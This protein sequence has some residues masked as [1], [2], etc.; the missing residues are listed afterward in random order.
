[1]YKNIY[2]DRKTGTVHLWDSK[3]GYITF[4]YQKYAYVQHPNGEYKTIYGTPVRKTYDL[5]GNRD[6]YFEIDV[7]DTTRILVDLYSDDDIPSDGHTVLTFDIEVEMESG[8][9]NPTMAN[10]TITSVAIHDSTTN[11][12]WV[13][14]LDDKKLITEQIKDNT[15]I[16]PFTTEREMLLN[17][18][19]IWEGINPSIIT[20]WNTDGFDIPYIY[21]R[22]R[23][24]FG[25]RTANRLSPIGVVNY[26]SHREV[27][28]IAG[29]T[30]YDYLFL[31]RKFT[32]SEL[33][34]YKLDTIGK[35]EVKMGKIEY[36]GSLDKLFKTDLDKFIEY[37]L[38][39]ID[40]V[41]A[42][43]KKLQYIDLARSICHACCVPYEELPYSS[44]YL[45]GAI[46]AHLKKNN[47]VAMNK[48]KRIK[49][50]DDVGVGFAGAYVKD[51]IVGVYK[52]IYD[53]DLTSLYP[54]I[55]MSLNISPETKMLKVT[56]WN[57]DEYVKGNLDELVF[58]NGRT[59]PLDNFKKFIEEAKLSIASNGVM[60]RKDVE[61]IIPSI[62]RTWFDKRT[63]FRKLES[64]YGKKGD[65]GRYAFYNKRQTT[66]KILLNSLYG[67][68]GL[69][70]WRFFDI[71]NAEA[72]TT[73]GVS[74]IQSTS[75]IL[76]LKYS[77]ELGTSIDSN[78]N[79][80]YTIY[81][82]TDSVFASATPLLDFRHPNW[83]TMDDNDI[84]NLVQDIAGEMQD[85]INQF[86]DIFSKRVFN[87]DTHRFEIKKE[88]VSKAGM[89]IAKKRYAQWIVS[90]NGI[91]MDKLDVK[92]LD[93]VRS[94]FP[95]A[96]RKFM[97]EILMDILK[98]MTPSDI[99][100]KILDFKNKLVDVGIHN[101]AKNTSVKELT[102]YPADT[103]TMFKF[104]SA[105]PA[106][107]KATIAYNQLLKHFKC[108]YSY[109]PFKDGSKVKWVYLK[110]NPFGLDGLSF[111]GDGEDPIE[112][113]QF[114][115]Q[116]VDYDKIFE[117]E[118][119]S[120]FQDIYNALKWGLVINNKR[121]AEKF[122]DF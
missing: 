10:N 53:L 83:K 91:P 78:S 28:Q 69:N 31:Y 67:T 115:E 86:Y 80:D 41:I 65:M 9:P 6:D 61:G 42:L 87:L 38:R 59:M 70:G 105:T 119:L 46:L 62:L 40:I 102:K 64:E 101:I 114:I 30:S 14:V 107:V 18:I 5:D 73:S 103:S 34:N 92:G 24:L 95:I 110:N 23:K 99:S 20:G 96:F 104:K 33:E 49:T 50:D 121:N 25:E 60:Y 35:K 56:N 88:Y 12:R 22:L 39:D 13:L 44:I 36:Q 19:A 72:V 100:D 48:P 52:W 109:P 15:K 51:P 111:N 57:I 16:L 81:I 27:Y 32:M 17:F 29:V 11:D 98:D 89:W 108:G 37:N 113:I 4:P 2:L 84:A 1:M 68:L 8:M 43:D 26:H 47:L 77:K 3:K 74:I 45:E 116:Y 75:R 97:A 54:S 21:N 112:I 7:P 63:E 55:I 118:L 94:S 120:K 106:H 76:N 90:N 85:H 93:V 79:A 82:D 117:K 122:F 71:D 58:D 66:Q